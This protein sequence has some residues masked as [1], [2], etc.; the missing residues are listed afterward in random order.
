MSKR[1][2]RDFQSLQTKLEMLQEGEHYRSDLQPA[3]KERMLFKNPDREES[4]VDQSKRMLSSLP[5]TGRFERDMNIDYLNPREELPKFAKYV[6]QIPPFDRGALSI[7][8]PYDFDARQQVNRIIEGRS[9]YAIEEGKYDVT[10]ENAKEKLQQRLKIPTAIQ[11]DPQ[12][13]R[14]EKRELARAALMETTSA[15]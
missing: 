13:T 2:K 7:Y 1:R 10:I 12:P 9:N 15:L 4:N 8:K 5:L 3:P 14:S 11:S 6:D